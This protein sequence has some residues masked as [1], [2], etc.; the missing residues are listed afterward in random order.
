VVPNRFPPRWRLWALWLLILAAYSNSFH[1]GLVFDNA[2]AIADDPRIREPTAKNIQLILTQDYWYNRQN[3]GLYRPVTTLSYLANYAAFGNGAQPEAYHWVNLA[4]HLANAGLVYALGTLVFGDAAIALSCAALWGLHPLL[5]ESVTNIVGRA[6]LLAAF[7]TLAGLLCYLKSAAVTGRRRAAWLAGMAAAQTMG[8]FSKE[9]AAVLPG[10]MLVYDLIWPKRA[11]WSARWPAYALLLLPFALFFSLRAAAHTHIVPDL[12]ENPLV[13]AGFWTA[14]LTALKVIGKYLWLFIWPARLS[15]DYSFNAIP[16]F[17]WHWEDAQVIFT[18]AAIAG[19]ALWAIKSKQRRTL[20]FF[21][22]FFVV[23]LA[24]V[25]NLIILIGTVMAERLVYLPAVG[26]AG[27]LAIAIRSF[28]GRFQWIVIGLVCLAFGAR[29]YA[30]NFDWADELSLWTS[31]VN[32]YPTAARPHNNL[33]NALAKIPG[34]LPEAVTEYEA[35]LRIKPGDA[36]VHY[37]LGNALAEIPGS[38]PA[39]IAEYREALRIDPSYTKAHINLGNALAKMPGGFPEAAAQYQAV[40]RLEPANA[41][42]HFNLGNLLAAAPGRSAGAIAEYRAA[43]AADPDK[44][45]AHYNLANLLAIQ[46]GNLAEA[47]AEYEA[48]LRLEP[49]NADAHYNLAN[50]LASQPDTLP[51]A[52]AEYRAAI[53]ADPRKVQAHNNLGSIF[54]QIPGRLPDAMAEYEAALQIDPANA[55]AHYNLGNALMS[56]PG[57]LPD[58]IAQY[59][60]AVLSQPS[61]AEAHFNLGKALAQTPGKIPE[62]I[63]EFEIVLRLGPDPDAQQMLQK[64]RALRR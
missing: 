5:T 25:S 33:G 60:A 46:R 3:S 6:D 13:Q 56:L 62:A 22:L 38:L 20:L 2:K 8:L 28:T 31:T 58:A 16:L 14:R 24:P 45:E 18:L 57:R 39:A 53:A 12:A 50:L 11:K 35:A 19:L 43:I 40:F 7:G 27:C 34:R 4:L 15:A 64:L 52:I 26:L 54:S 61:F 42:A 10:L 59:Q 63:A 32:A 1:A 48:V 30:R 37:N 36:D 9:N 49:A 44:A 21:L 51:R 47:A 23:C 41:D 55:E 17:G 29:T